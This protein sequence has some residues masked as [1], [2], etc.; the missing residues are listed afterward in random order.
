MAVHSTGSECEGIFL[1][2]CA[3]PGLLPVTEGLGCTPFG[4]S[5]YPIHVVL[6]GHPARQG[7]CPASQELAGVQLP[8]ETLLRYGRTESY[9]P[10]SPSTPALLLLA[11]AW[12]MNL[13][14]KKCSRKDRMFCGPR[15]F[16]LGI[17]QVKRAVCGPITSIRCVYHYCS[18]HWTITQVRNEHSSMRAW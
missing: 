16:R 12:Q 15:P 4:L 13:T 8:M 2:G 11:T 18:Q 17:E 6:C 1:G 10:C 14:A 7:R 3:I 9:Q 5:E